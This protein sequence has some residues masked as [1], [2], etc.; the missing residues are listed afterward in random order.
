M[1]MLDKLRNGERVYGTA[2]TSIAPSW[3]MSL[4]KA[5]LD[6]VFIDNEHPR[7]GVACQFFVTFLL[8][9]KV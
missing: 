5:A 9:K 7:A 6:F 3:A 2:F 8:T 1:M 4:K